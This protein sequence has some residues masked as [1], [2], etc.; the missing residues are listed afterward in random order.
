MVGCFVFVNGLRSGPFC[1]WAV[2]NI[3]MFM[4]SQIHLPVTVN[5]VLQFNQ[6]LRLA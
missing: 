5:I 6:V 4:I 1:R 2:W 3:S